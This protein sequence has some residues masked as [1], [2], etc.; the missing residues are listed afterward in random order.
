[1]AW[2]R[3]CRAIWS[4]Y[5]STPLGRRCSLPLR[6]VSKLFLHATTKF[7]KN[8][9][10]L[11]QSH[12]ESVVQVSF[13]ALTSLDALGALSVLPLKRLTLRCIGAELRC[14]KGLALGLAHARWEGLEGGVSWVRRFRLLRGSANGCVNWLPPFQT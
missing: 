11:P 2:R 5:T 7:I 6:S 9:Q 10:L 8:R 3:T 14:A 12:A 4:P 13:T 1:M